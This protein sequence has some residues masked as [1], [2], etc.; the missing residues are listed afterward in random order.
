MRNIKE[1]NAASQLHTLVARSM[2]L[3][4]MKQFN[5]NYKYLIE[6]YD[7]SSLVLSGSIEV[8]KLKEFQDLKE[9]FLLNIN[10]VMP[11]LIANML[12][13]DIFA[14]SI[15]K[16]LSSNII[17]YH[18]VHNDSTL[19]NEFG[20]YGGAEDSMAILNAR[21]WLMT[22]EA[23]DIFNHHTQGH[24]VE[25]NVNEMLGVINQHVDCS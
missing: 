4:G 14:F 5:H 12:E 25:C 22:E 1:N 21:H 23:V 3:E 9:Y 2:K 6:S 8:G 13:G 19:K 18:D 16:E 11:K 17:S 7:N 15:Y 10:T 24:D 20:K